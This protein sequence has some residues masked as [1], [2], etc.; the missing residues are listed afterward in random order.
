[1]QFTGKCVNV[2]AGAAMVALFTACTAET[3]PVEDV[4]DAGD[5][6]ESPTTET[7]QAPDTSGVA[8]TSE[9]ATIE[10]ASMKSVLDRTMTRIDGTPQNLSEYRGKVVLVVNT[11]SK[12]GLTPQYG[13]LQSLYESKSAD[14]LVILGFPANNFGGQE[15]GTDSEITQFCTEN[16]GVT[17]PMFSKISV[18][19]DDQD[20]LFAEL[21]SQTEDPSW[22]FTKYLIGRDGKLVARFDPKTTPD[23][24]A[25]VGRIEELLNAG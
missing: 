18:T 17:F 1:M 2:I 20:A 21:S 3:A 10:N 6:A 8:P 22:N 24:A 12:C 19:G 9:N 13:E 14:G 4:S 11:A 23:D 25:L 16:Y 5:T 15:P 7:A